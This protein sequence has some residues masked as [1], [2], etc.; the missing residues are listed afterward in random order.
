MK[1]TWNFNTKIADT[2]PDTIQHWNSRHLVKNNM[3]LT[4]WN[5]VKMVMFRLRHALSSI[6]QNKWIVW[7]VEWYAIRW[8][9]FRND[10]IFDEEA[11]LRCIHSANT[12]NSANSATLSRHSSY[13]DVIN[14]ILSRGTNY[15]RILKCDEDPASKASL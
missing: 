8:I 7:L 10:V 11:R 6:H 15:Y 14:L 3:R 2:F 12:A 13:C 5:I 1:K 9:D 4:T